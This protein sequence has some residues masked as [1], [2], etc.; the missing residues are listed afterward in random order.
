M[1]SGK[2]VKKFQKALLKT[3]GEKE[4][5]NGC[6]LQLT[7]KDFSHSDDSLWIVVDFD[8]NNEIRGID[9]VDGLPNKIRKKK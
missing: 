2:I 1:E 7:N 9:F 5:K 8:K 4:H 3:C 6:Y